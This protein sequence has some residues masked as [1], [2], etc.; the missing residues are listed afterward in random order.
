MKHLNLS[1]SLSNMMRN[2]Y[3]SRIK[4]LAYIMV[5]IIIYI[6]IIDIGI[7]I[8][9]KYP[10]SMESV[11]PSRLQMYFENGR[12]V[13]GKFR[14]M[15][16]ASKQESESIVTHG[17]L[18]DE[19][20]YQLPSI[21]NKPSEKLIALYGMSHTKL[22]GEALNNLDENY[23][24]RDIT[25][26]GAPANWAY[27]AYSMDQDKHEADVVILGIMTDG[28]SKISTTTGATM[29]FDMSYPY[30][31]PRLLLE[32]NRLEVYYPPYINER[33]Y[34]KYLNDPKMWNEY[35]VWLKQYDK[36]YDPIL[37]NTNIFDDSSVLRLLRR[38]YAQYSRNRKQNTVYNGD[39]F[40]LQSEEILVL[41]KIIIDFAYSA[42]KKNILPIIYIVNSPNRSDHLFRALELILRDHDIPYLSTHE[43]CPPDNPK[44]FLENTHFTLEKDME[45]ADEIIKIIS[46]N[47]N[48]M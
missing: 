29:H 28:I 24:I 16:G 23:I 1:I 12:S 32:E 26:P 9:F 43:I 45:L 44:I 34:I 10:D 11:N 25:A 38:A 20:Y 18:L 47:D 39:G 42:K 4:S 19:E 31:Y 21:T 15:T 41:K 17:W 2:I 8:I 5:W 33:D 37:F 30:T 13:E 48:Q 3:K 40:N 35:K 46:R 14:N 22:L 36:Y 7:N 6:V 27:S